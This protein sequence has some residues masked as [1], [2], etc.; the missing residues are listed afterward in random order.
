LVGG[1]EWGLSG[2]GYGRGAIPLPEKRNF[3]LEVVY[4]GEF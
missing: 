3:S 4:F 1:E 2:E